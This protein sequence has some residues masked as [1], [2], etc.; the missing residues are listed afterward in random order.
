MREYAFRPYEPSLQPLIQ[1]LYAETHN[2]AMAGES[3][4]IQ[5]LIKIAISWELD[6]QL[7]DVGKNYNTWP[8]RFFMISPLDNWNEVAGYCALVYYDEESVEVKNVIVS[9]EHQGKGLGRMLMEAVEE[10]AILEEYNRIVLMTYQH[11]SVA[12]QMYEKRG[13]KYMPADNFMDNP[14]I[15]PE[16]GLLAMELKL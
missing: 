15:I 8:N 9:P 2:K 5:S 13:Y 14:I 11:L 10:T 1:Q 12:L 7:A 4:E 6:D 16:L 3:E